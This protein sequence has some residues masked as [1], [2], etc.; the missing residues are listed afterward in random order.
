MCILLEIQTVDVVSPRAVLLDME[1]EV[2]ASLALDLI[3]ERRWLDCFVHCTAVLSSWTCL[4]T[5][6]KVL[7][8]AKCGSSPRLKVGM[9]LSTIDDA[10]GS[11]C[12]SPWATWKDKVVIMS[13][14]YSES[15][16]TGDCTSNPSTI[17][18]VCRKR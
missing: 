13:L 10:P 3:A 17:E 14:F 4:P 9:V 5:F 12:S 16:W 15:A 2:L 7:I 8:P 18:V 6:M 1:S 11:P